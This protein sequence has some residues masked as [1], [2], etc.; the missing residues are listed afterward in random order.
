MDPKVLPP[1][2]PQ[3]LTVRSPPFCH[4][5]RGNRTSVRCTHWLFPFS[6]RR[7][8]TRQYPRGTLQTQIQWGASQGTEPQAPCG[9][10][11]HGLCSLQLR[12]LRRPSVPNNEWCLQ[13]GQGAWIERGLQFVSDHSECYKGDTPGCPLSQLTQCS[14]ISQTSSQPSFYSREG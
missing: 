11:F 2:A 3:P 1:A 13:P 6:E 12:V 4:M 8:Y 10:D 9:Q 5:P 14:P 7:L